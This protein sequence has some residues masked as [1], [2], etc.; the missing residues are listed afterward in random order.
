MF[1]DPLINIRSTASNRVFQIGKLNG[2]SFPIALSGYP[3][4]VHT[5]L[6]TEMDAPELAAFFMTLGKQQTPWKSALTWSS[7]EGDLSLSVTCTALGCVTFQVELSGLLGAPE[8]WRIQAGIE[9]GLGDLDRL[10]REA[11]ELKIA[12]NTIF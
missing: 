12:C 3:I 7:L 9:T 4:S 1:I 5:Q 10:A 6:W 8:E 2:H 11:E